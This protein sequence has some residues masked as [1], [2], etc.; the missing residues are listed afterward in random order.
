MSSDQT[1]GNNTAKVEE[2]DVQSFKPF[3]RFRDLLD[4]KGSDLGS[5]AIHFYPDLLHHYWTGVDPLGIS[6]CQVYDRPKVVDITE[7]HAD[8]QEGI[9]PL[10][11]DI[12]IH[13]GEPGNFAK[14]RVFRVPRGTCVVLNRGVWHHAPFLL[15]PA[16]VV[17]NVLI[18]L[19]VETYR[20]DCRPIELLPDNQVRITE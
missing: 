17:A 6:I 4:P 14:V 11:A 2:L 20:K 1:G 15:D 18:L 9:L 13:V 12:L 3:G 7:I 16:D 8:T 19:P 10:D 5:G